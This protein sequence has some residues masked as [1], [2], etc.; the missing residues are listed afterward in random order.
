M[1]PELWPRVEEL[2]H[3]ALD[4]SPDARPAFLEK[5]C[6]EDA[7]LRR[8][9]ELLI[10][11]DEHAGSL[12]EKPILADVVPQHE[13]EDSSLPTSAV[14]RASAGANPSRIGTRV[15]T[16]EFVSLLGAGGMGEVYRAHDRKLRRDVAIKVL[17]AVVANDPSRVSRFQ[18]EART[19]A[20]LN[21]PY[22]GA[23]YGLEETDNGYALVLE[24]I[25]GPTL[26]QRL[27]NGRRIP[28]QETLLI[29]RQIAEALEAAHD[30]GIIHR[31]LKPANIKVT[32]AGTVKVL[33]FGLAKAF[34][35][36]SLA[37][38]SQVPA[39][40]EDGLIVGTPSYMSPEQARGQA[41]T[42]Q[43]DIWAFGC[44]LYELLTGKHA[45]HEKTSTDTIVAVL[46]REPDWTQLP[47]SVSPRLRDLLRLCLEK[48]IRNRRSTAAD[49][50]IDIELALKEPTA[51]PALSAPAKSRRAWLPWAVA[52]LA[53]V[54]VA[55]MVLRP[56]AV[57]DNPLANAR[58]TRLTD[59]PGTE[60]GAAVSP[61]GRF[62]VFL[63]D[64]DGPPDV[65]LTQVGTG[66][67][68]N[69]TQGNG[70]LLGR[71]V[72]V[73]GFSADGSEVWF[74]K[75]PGGPIRIMPLM[76]G[77]PRVFLG[78]RSMNV[79]WAP[80][81]SRMV[82]HTSDPGDP[83]FVADGSGDNARQIFVGSADRHNHFPAWSP[84]GRWIY[85]ASG[86][87]IVNEMDLWRISSGGGMPER[88]THQNSPVAYP[89]PISNTTVL[90]VARDSTG[91]GP[92]LWAMD[93]ERNATRRISLGVEK[94][95]SIAASADGRR[96]AATVGNP[97]ATLWSVPI[98]DRLAGESDVKPYPLPSVRAL[99]PRFGADALFYVSSQGAGGEGLWRHQNGEVIEICR[100]ATAALLE[101]PA[102]SADGRRVAFVLR[103]N[104]SLRLH[105]ETGEGTESQDLASTL[106]IR[107][108]PCWS[109]DGKWIV[110]G[111]NDGKGEGLFKIPV[112]G[113][114]A[115]RV[116]TGP[117]ANPVWSPDG[118]IIVYAG[119]NAVGHTPLLAVRPDGARIEW[120][121]ITVNRDG[122]RIRFLPSGKSLVYMQGSNP[123]QDFWILDIATT[124]TRQLTRLTE[125]ATMR[126]FDI[127]PDGKQIV[128]DRLRENSDIVL[129]DLP[130]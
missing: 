88:L 34:A 81:G 70:P 87:P 121:N 114:E 50:R 106:A 120:P 128:F 101:P 39:G 10:S 86:N 40:S 68:M 45:F 95:S 38:L 84:D 25:E 117:A 32:P 96:L 36:D 11:K 44:V 3:A 64:R 60:E 20:A 8:H 62:V 102:V 110:I 80:D 92:W 61:D 18:R 9:V 113:G 69:L 111:G 130:K 22:I 30:K 63:A 82:Y 83:M 59:S 115:V 46:E 75:E 104:G 73:V 72:R 6:G 71:T 74:V 26:A 105:V 79:A 49:V 97:T 42:K 28:V 51:E 93:V 100:G 41:V 116:A 126:T 15:G 2:F 27:A 55:W 112:D 90:Y 98:L 52:V 37:D 16:Y 103:Q 108:A 125:N 19:L 122:E 99:M 89:T 78:P 53:A 118:T 119:A 123:I 124:R 66:Q 85:F 76:G 109:P 12:L 54:Y 29:A 129:I 4:L 58:F 77:K 67:F 57:I 107:G 13:N 7:G 14:N 23:I 33:D 43:T 94:Y 35:S 65:F 1:N 127:T 5:A 17:P 48:N 24:L 91:A 56:V 47:A 21:H 31:D